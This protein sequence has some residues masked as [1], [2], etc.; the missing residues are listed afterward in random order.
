[1]TFKNKELLKWMYDNF[2]KWEFLLTYLNGNG[3]NDQ[4]MKLAYLVFY[5]FLN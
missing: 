1:M 4:K 2:R 3:K 5:F